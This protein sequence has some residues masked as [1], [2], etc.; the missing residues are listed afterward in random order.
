M[1]ELLLVMPILGPV[2][3]TEQRYRER[4][5]ER[6]GNITRIDA[7][8]IFGIAV[9]TPDLIRERLRRLHADPE[10]VDCLR[11]EGLHFDPQGPGATPGAF[12]RAL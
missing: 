5:S 1:A 12:P 4:A 8:D 3:D 10:R 6:E 2:T 7:R 11:R 9:N